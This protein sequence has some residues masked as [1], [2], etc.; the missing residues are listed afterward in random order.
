[1][2]RSRLTAGSWQFEDAAL[3]AL[4][5]KVVGG[6][7]TLGEVYGPPLYGIK[8][9]LNDA[10]VIDRATRDRLVER[11]PRSAELLKP[12]I[13]G[14]DISRWFIEPQ[15]RGVLERV[16]GDHGRHGFRKRRCEVLVED[17]PHAARRRSDATAYSTSAAVR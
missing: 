10:F 14:D 9:G 7:P 11:D 13:E 8:T 5:A 2:P 17:E 16:A 12:F 4:R 15:D 1:M 6:R 3:A